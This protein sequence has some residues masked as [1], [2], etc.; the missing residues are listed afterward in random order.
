[1]ELIRSGLTLKQQNHL[2]VCM[3]I[4]VADVK[5]I[6]SRTLLICQHSRIKHNDISLLT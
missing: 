1:M 2:H 6:Q 4:S 3:Q 5:E